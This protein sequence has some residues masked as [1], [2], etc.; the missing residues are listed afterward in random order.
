MQQA[1]DNF[2][3]PDLA[4]EYFLQIK[5]HYP[6]YTRD[7]IQAITKSLSATNTVV[8]DKTLAFC[9]NNNIINGN[10]WAQALH[11]LAYENGS[12]QPMEEVKLLDE[13]NMGKASQTP[14]T[15]NIDD[16]ENLIN[17]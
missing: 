1:A 6:R 8:A 13:N 15:S 9:L 5:K 2:T 11:V 4:M 17:S 3:N 10:E 7:H 16:Y 12:Q 14:Q